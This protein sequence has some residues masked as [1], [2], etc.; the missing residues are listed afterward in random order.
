MKH[1]I[2]VVICLLGFYSVSYGET[3]TTFCKY[4]NKV[5][6]VGDSTVVVFAKFGK[7]FY[8]EIIVSEPIVVKEWS[9]IK[10]S[11]VYVIRL[12]QGRV[13]SIRTMISR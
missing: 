13:K 3:T 10:K 1:I 9:Y 8:E 2:I 4:N 6:H 5:I 7:P 11:K 12:R